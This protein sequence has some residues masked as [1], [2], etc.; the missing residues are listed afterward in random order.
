[1]RGGQ[2]RSREPFPSGHREGMGSS[3][4]CPLGLAPPQA[5]LP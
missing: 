4:A 2:G 3:T 5:L 1:M